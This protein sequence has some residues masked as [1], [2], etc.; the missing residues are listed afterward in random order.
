MSAKAC[1]EDAEEKGK[2]RNARVETVVLKRRGED[3]KEGHDKIAGGLR[4]LG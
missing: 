2:L 1:S 4:I 3:A